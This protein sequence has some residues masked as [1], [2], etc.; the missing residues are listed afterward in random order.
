[1]RDLRPVDPTAGRAAD[2]AADRTADAPG[3]RSGATVTLVAVG[4]RIECFGPDADCPAPVEARVVDAGG[5]WIL[6][7]LID[8]HVQLPRDDAPR[9]AGR[10]QAV[11]LM[12]GITTVRDAGTPGGDGTGGREAASRV[13]SP[14]APVPRIVRSSRLS[15]SA[16]ERRG[17][18]GAAALVRLVVQE[19][20]EAIELEGELPP[21]ELRAAVEAAHEAGVPVFGR[22]WTGPPFRSFLREALEAGVDGITH[23]GA[24]PIAVLGGGLTPPDSVSP[25]RVPVWR[26]ALWLD[27]DLDELRELARELARRDVWLEPLLLETARFEAPYGVPHELRRLLELPWMLERL[28]RKPAPALDAETAATMAAALDRMRSFVREFHDAGGHVI[29]GTDDA[30]APGLAL[31]EELRQLVEAGLTPLDAIRAATRDAAVALGVEDRVGTLERGK[32]ADFVILEEDPRVGIERTLRIWRVG[33]HGR[34][35]DPNVLYDELTRE[36]G[37]LSESWAR[38][39]VAIVAM[40]VALLALAWAIHTSGRGP[41]HPGPRRVRWR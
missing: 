4:G 20:A 9:E 3:R 26:E 7:G 18:A 22:G 21:A 33:K 41:P 19:G 36:P 5:R 32:R 15:R 40:A 13:A 16:I 17:A 23:L 27:A 30:L 12:L 11:R 34:V 14:D 10:D 25:D 38:L 2:P 28:L 39:L 6:P 1:M 35:Y 31:H 37:I 8:S 29:T 24:M